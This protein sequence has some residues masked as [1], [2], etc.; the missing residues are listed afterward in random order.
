MLD[1]RTKNTGFRIYYSDTSVMK[2]TQSNTNIKI[3]KK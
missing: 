1:L 3:N 2:V